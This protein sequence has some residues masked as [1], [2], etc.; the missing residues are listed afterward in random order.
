VEAALG[1]PPEDQI[2]EALDA[3][4]AGELRKGM[5]TFRK[6]YQEGF[7]APTLLRKALEVL[8]KG[9][10]EASPEE[11]LRK[12]GFASALEEGLSRVVRAPDLL[13][14]EGALLKGVHERL[15]TRNLPDPP[16]PK[17]EESPPPPPQPREEVPA[18]RGEGAHGRKVADWV[19]KRRKAPAKTLPP[20]APEESTAKEVVLRGA[21]LIEAIVAN[22]AE[23]R[24]FKALLNNAL[25][26]EIS[27]DGKTLRIFF[28][29][30]FTG[31]AQ[32]VSAYLGEIEVALQRAF[33]PKLQEKPQIVVGALEAEAS[34]GRRVPEPREPPPPPRPKKEGGASGPP[35]ATHSLTKPKSEAGSLPAEVKTIYGRLKRTFGEVALLGVKPKKDRFA[36]EKDEGMVEDL[37]EGHEEG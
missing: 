16:S 37:V 12:L 6:L 36:E 10:Y 9:V 26:G 34:K 8:Q 20:E 2:A 22:M 24:K 35:L 32:K 3:M 5:E 33:G 29:P 30:G 19:A 31:N 14:L 17:A 15:L 4:L 13:S 21:E 28:P 25:K 7:S 18:R 1:L 11:A 27:F 23:R